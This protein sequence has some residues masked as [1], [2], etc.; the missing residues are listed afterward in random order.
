MVLATISLV[1]ALLGGLTYRFMPRGAGHA[2]DAKAEGSKKPVTIRTVMMVVVSV[3]VLV[4]SAIIILRPESSADSQKLA[5]GAL[6]TI[7]GFW[8]R[9]D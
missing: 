8:L 3:A 1:A 6:G 2:A 5:F 7:I 4:I 9:G